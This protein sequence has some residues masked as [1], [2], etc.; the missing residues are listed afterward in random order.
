MLNKH[1]YDIYDDD[2]SDIYYESLPPCLS[3]VLSS[4]V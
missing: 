2:I 1:I 3:S 4:S